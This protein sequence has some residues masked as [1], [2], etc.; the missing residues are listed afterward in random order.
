MKRINWDGK[1][2]KFF[3][4]LTDILIVVAAYILAVMMV[5]GHSLGELFAGNDATRDSLITIGILVVGAFIFFRVY[6]I[7]ITQR[8]YVSVMFRSIISF[9]I[10][11][12]IL[13][14]FV[15]INTYYTLPRTAIALM[16]IYQI[17]AFAVLKYIAYVILKRVNIKTSLIFGPQNEVDQLAK[18]ILY[19]DNI[20]IYLKYLVYDDFQ[21]G[22]ISKI[23]NY[24]QNI[25]YVYL[26]ESLSED[27][28]N[29]IISYCYK[30]KKSFF[31][32][33]KLYE[34]SINNAQVSQ[35]GDTLLY[36]VSGLGLTVEQRFFKRAFDLLV[37]FIGIIVAAPFM[38][39]IAIAIKLYDK[40]PV[41]YKQER[42][43]L[44]NKTFML[45]KFRSMIPD[46]EAKTGAVQAS[47]NDPRIT[48][49]GK[50][51]RKTRLD[52]LPQLF[53]V[54]KGEMS[55]VGPRALRVEEVEEF[56]EYNSEF[57]YRMNVKAGITG[58]AQTM[59][60]YYTNYNDKLRFDIFYISNYSFLADMMI[61]LHTVRSL[62]DP[63]SAEG[64]SEDISLEKC[65]SLEGYHILNTENKFIRIVVTR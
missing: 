12:L 39:I 58:Y 23:Y 4:R 7:S 44:D 57:R 14:V 54:L 59:G 53:N 15:L 49:I 41:L 32:V 46:A 16:I 34:L 28:K 26:T 25:D 51:L 65:L 56:I 30:I 10:I 38:V 36:E 48:P 24:I 18:K 19:D 64:L 33:P 61:I 27:K 60:K 20:F 62:F 5:S 37:S 6:K 50:F 40:G 47:K 9:V 8:S 2:T 1:L 43:T 45:S 22:E 11:G 52:E 17:I 42:M 35:V 55:L 63:Q 13:Y 3:E 21:N 29:I 31:L